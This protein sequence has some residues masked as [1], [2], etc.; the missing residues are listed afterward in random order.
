LNL[1]AYS[2]PFTV[3]AAAGGA[4][5]TM[6]VDLY[7][8]ALEWAKRNLEINALTNANNAFAASD[9]FGWLEGAKKRTDR[10]DLVILDP[11]SYSTTRD[12]TRFSAASDYRALAALVF[13]VI[14]PGGQ[15]LA[16]SNHRGIVNAKF[17][18]FLYE[19]AHDAGANVA[20]MQ[21]LATPSDFPAQPGHEAHLK[22]VLV[23]LAR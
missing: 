1:F 4:T 8:G 5:R 9:V 7:A 3:A 6:S 15:L 11:P 2:G 22:S 19:A 12:G 18:R 13:G 23:T 21:D 16:C 17:R 10:F 14:A 20:R